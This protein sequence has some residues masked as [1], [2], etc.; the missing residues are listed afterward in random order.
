MFVSQS[1]LSGYCLGNPGLDIDALGDCL[2][3]SSVRLQ[4]GDQIS[5]KGSVTILL[6]YFISC[7]NNP[8]TGGDKILALNIHQK[9]KVQ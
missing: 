2:E 3:S 8:G 1:A 7:N 5:S 4:S 9:I 6:F